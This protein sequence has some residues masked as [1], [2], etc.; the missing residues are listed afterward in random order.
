MEKLPNIEKSLE[1]EVMVG[2]KSLGKGRLFAISSWEGA[3]SNGVPWKKYVKA[4]FENVQE[5]AIQI[6]EARLPVKESKAEL[7]KK[8]NYA[9]TA[10]GI[11]IPADNDLGF[12]QIAMARPDIF[13]LGRTQ[14]IAVWYNAVV[15]GFRTAYLNDGPRSSLTDVISTE[16]FSRLKPMIKGKDPLMFCDSICNP[17]ETHL[18]GKKWKVLVDKVDCPS[19]TAETPEEYETPA[20]QVGILVNRI[21]S[22]SLGEMLVREYFKQ[23]YGTQKGNKLMLAAVQ[24]VAALYK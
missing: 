3:D 16:T 1:A 2:D 10:M 14:V 9:Y 13:D 17:N 22:H 18:L 20:F 24:K 19:L 11:V 12:R 7:S 6:E 23:G 8:R 4:E 15:P 5:T 21:P